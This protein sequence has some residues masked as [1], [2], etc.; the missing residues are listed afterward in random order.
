MRRIGVI[1]FVLS[2]LIY[3]LYL[4]LGSGADQRAVLQVFHFYIV[5]F[6]TFAAAV[7]SILLSWTLG[8]RAAPRHFLS[9]VA[10]AAI[11]VLF[12]SHGFATP[13][14][15]IAGFSP[16]LQWSAWLTLMVSGALFAV[17]SINDLKWYPKIISPRVVLWM[18]AVFIGG[19]YLVA[20]GWPGILTAIEEQAAPWHQLAIFSATLI[21]WLFAAVNFF[22]IWRA[23]H[24]ITDA[25]LAY[26]AF[27]LGLAAVSM[28]QFD[29]W[30]LSWWMYHFL[31]LVSFLLGSYFLVAEYEHARRFNLLRYFLAVSLNVTALLVLASTF[32]YSAAAT[33]SLSEE[34]LRQANIRANDF[35][36]GTGAEFD[37]GLSPDAQLRGYE[38]A[39]EEMPALG[40]YIYDHNGRIFSDYSTASVETGGS[41]GRA[42]EMISGGKF[43][44]FAT[45]LN[46]NTVAQILEPASPPEGYEGVSGVHTIR[47]FAPLLN[48]GGAEPI[49]VVEIV[50]ALP[51]LTAAARA[52]RVTGITIA[53]SSAL[54]L[55]VALLFVVNRGDRILFERA[56]DLNRAFADLKRSEAIRDDLTRMI[57]H[58]LRNPLSAISASID[59][60]RMTDRDPIQQRKFTTLA[61][62]AT[63]RMSGMVDD[64]L[65]VSKYEAGELELKRADVSVP[66]VL[67]A[68]V[69][70]FQPQMEAEEKEMT[71]EC[72]PEMRASF[73]TQLIGRVLDNLIGNASKYIQAG[74][75]RIL[76]RALEREQRLIVSV[77]DNGPGVP[78]EY[79]VKIFQKFVQVP[80]NDSEIRKGTGL[81]LAFC[82]M[83]VEAH[84]GEIRVSDIRGG[85]SDFTFWIPVAV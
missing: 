53:G 17:G 54:V 32:L 69:E 14:I 70:A 44:H 25:I 66:R 79:K 76:V 81:G 85:G 39:L 7:I 60:I 24:S 47:I 57:V 30:F 74:E 77:R 65:T 34:I 8:G 51:D 46:L 10:F 6:T 42:G 26:I 84:G 63:R 33:H 18:T 71:L 68:V 40:F 48:A 82:R 58:D 38:A 36:R 20:L 64:L 2:P 43:E 75:G 1:L 45:A 52:A 9:A 23:T 22:R 61:Q 4:R 13:G 37:P 67:V 3:I 83:V 35:V 11:G 15:L 62:D 21:F 78:D 19:Y 49:G 28:H 41:A 12:F 31:M 73:D 56:R 55:F 80:E 29:V 5:T 72:P 59:L 50:D 27:W 16:L